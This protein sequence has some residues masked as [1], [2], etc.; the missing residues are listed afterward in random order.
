MQ[1][2]HIARVLRLVEFDRCKQEIEISERRVGEPFIGLGTEH[3][4]FYTDSL[5]GPSLAPRHT[6]NPM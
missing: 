6:E 4:P 5:K 2:L 3:D 1:V